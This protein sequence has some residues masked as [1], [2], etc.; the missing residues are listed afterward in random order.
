MK[1]Y[2]EIGEIVNTHGIKGEVK[3]KPWCDSPEFLCGIKNIYKDFGKNLIKVLS[4]RVN[5]NNVIMSI[6]QID[7]IERAIPLI[8]TVLYADRDDMHLDDDTYFIQDIIGCSVY[9]IDTGVKY[10][11][12]SDVFKTGAND[13]Y[14]VTNEK[15]QNYLVPVVKEFVVNVDINSQKILVKPIKGIFDDAN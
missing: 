13:V 2:L 15:S 4:A 1:K 7:S 10:G 9:D 6:D 14:Q 5:K 3:V 11:A 12:V 8:G